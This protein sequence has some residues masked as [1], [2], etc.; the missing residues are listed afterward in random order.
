MTASVRQPSKAALST[1]EHLPM[2]DALLG[3]TSSMRKAGEAYLP[4]WP[5]EEGESY[6]ARL[7][8]ATL[9]P[10][11]SHTVSILAGKPFSKQLTLSDDVPEMIAEWCEDIDLQGRNLHAF[12]ADL[13]RDCVSYGLSGVL[14]D[15]PTVDSVKTLAD[16]KKIGARPYFIRYAPG[17]VLGFRTR[18]VNGVEKLDQLRLLETVTEKDGAFG[19]KEIEQVRVL[20]PGTWATYRKNEKGDDWNLFEEGTTSLSEIPFVFFYGIRKGFGIGAPPLIELAFQNV[21]HWQSSSDQQTIVHVARVPILTIIGADNDTAITVGAS[22]A[23]KLP[24]GADMK[25]VEHSGAAIA[26][27]RET[28]KD[29]EERMRQTGA[30]LLVINPGVLTA[31]QT[32]SDNEGNKCVLQRITEIFEDALDQC[33][34]YLGMWINQDVTGNVTIF[35]DFGS[36][37]LS[38]ASAQLLLL[39]NQSGKLSDETLIEEWKRRNIL[40]PDVEFEDEQDRISEQGP[41]LGIVGAE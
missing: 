24:V 2:I 40:S 30:E 39:A 5:N 35:K 36:A 15:F 11:F 38:D 13:M 27:G 17:T 19:E 3:G 29:S 34:V 28:I 16:E 4:K 20:T 31:T 23:V 18:R 8:V 10:A 37:S 41:A 1:S 33:L 22:S 14:I 26:A 21:E 7:K 9:Y 12:A 6:Q 32:R 25:F